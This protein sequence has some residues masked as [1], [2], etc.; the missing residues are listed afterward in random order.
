MVTKYGFS[1]ELG[2]IN[3]ATSDDE[4]FIGRDIAHTKSFSE[5]TAAVI[6]QEVKRI[7]NDCHEKAK[8]ILK[9]NIEILHCLAGLLI[10][11]ERIGREEFES[12]FEQNNN[13]VLQKS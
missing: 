6:D 12:I 9:D 8:K 1:D 7:V 10:E 3:Y 4:V 2:M 11:K 13:N 5:E